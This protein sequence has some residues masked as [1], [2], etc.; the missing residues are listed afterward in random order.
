MNV[1]D[2]TKGIKIRKTNINKSLINDDDF[3]KDLMHVKVYLK[4]N[5]NLRKREKNGVWKMKC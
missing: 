1:S 4:I 5:K 3:R 2:V